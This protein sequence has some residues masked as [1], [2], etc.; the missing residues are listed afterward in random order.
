MSLCF[1]IETN[2]RNTYF[3]LINFLRRR[4]KQSNATSTKN[5]RTPNM[6]PT[7]KPAFALDPPPVSLAPKVGTTLLLSLQMWRVTVTM[8][9]LTT[10]RLF[11]L[12]CVGLCVWAGWGSVVNSFEV[13]F[14]II[15]GGVWIMGG[16]FDNSFV[17]SEL[18]V[19]KTAIRESGKKY[20]N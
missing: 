19:V 13:V 2:Y 8:I 18:G 5:A 12:S 9:F 7:I 16:R 10:R 6:I 3:F 1:F 20:L 11:N 14:F 17:V 4:Q 15:G